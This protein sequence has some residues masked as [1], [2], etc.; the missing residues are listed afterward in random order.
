MY[1]LQRSFSSFTPRHLTGFGLF[2]DGETN[3]QYSLLPWDLVLLIQH[4][5]SLERTLQAPLFGPL[6]PGL[7]TCFQFRLNF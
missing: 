7:G 3:V 4:Q 6:N 1:F 2:G 5:G